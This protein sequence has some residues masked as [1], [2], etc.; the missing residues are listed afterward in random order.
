LRKLFVLVYIFFIFNLFYTI[1]NGE[2]QQMV[3]EKYTAQEELFL[4]NLARATLYCYLTD[5]SIPNID[6]TLIPEKLKE[7]RGCFVTLTKRNSGLRGC[8]GYLIPV[9]TIYDGVIN[10]AIAAAVSD[11]RFPAVKYD[12]LK[13]IRLEI[14]ILTLPKKLEISSSQDLLNKL[15]PLKDGVIIETPYGSSTFLPQVWEQLPAKEDFLSHLCSKHGAPANIWKD[16]SKISVSTYE[17][18]V[19]EDKVY[20]KIVTANKGAIAGAG[21]AEIIGKVSINNPVLK[22]I[23]VSQGTKIEPLTILS[24]ESDIIQNK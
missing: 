8:I 13:D 21:G 22:P 9:E 15:R 11:P 23:T 7:K 17:A 5:R 16:V 18:I 20:G 4:L 10:R 12:E 24:P 2:D 6:K 3:Q 19:F 1:A 14:S